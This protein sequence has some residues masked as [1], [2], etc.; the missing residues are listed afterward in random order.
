[1]SQRPFD[2]TDVAYIE[3]IVVG[4]TD[5]SRMKTDEE[6]QAD[7]DKVNKLLNKSPKGKIIGMEKGF[8]VYTIGEHQVCLQS[9]TYHIGFK[10]RPAK[11]VTLG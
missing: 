11:E 2:I 8:A 9:V 6:I 5:P 3:R 7:M 1:M 10:R 4:N